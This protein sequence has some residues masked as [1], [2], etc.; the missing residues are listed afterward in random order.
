MTTFTSI[1][2]RSIG[3]LSWIQYWRH[4]SDFKNATG[5]IVILYHGIDNSN[6][7]RLNTKF[8]SARKFEKQIRLIKKH[9]QIVD[10]QTL[11]SEPA[12]NKL[13]VAISFDDGFEN[14]YLVAKP[15]L[16]KYQVPATFF[17]SRPQ[18]H[19]YDILW[20]D[21]VDLATID[22][23]NKLLIDEKPF[24]KKGKEFVDVSGQSLKKMC[25]ASGR[26]F[27]EKIYQAFLPYSRF[28][29]EPKWNTFW[30]LMSEDQIKEISMNPLF[31]VGAHGIMHTS[32]HL[33]S[34]EEA[35]Q[36]LIL[37]KNN[38]ERIIKQPVNWFAYPQGS[39]NDKS[40]ELARTAGYQLQFLADLTNV[41]MIDKVYNRMG[42]NPYLSASAQLFHFFTGKY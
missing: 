33:L 1:K 10:L 25:T 8:I 34:L 30:K 32:I 24:Y 14:N 23:P 9:F 17:I 39:A 16:E 4:F 11:C 6:Q 19:G 18:V 36:E 15:I 5:K 35:Q 13:Q 40:I 20:A 12:G 27:I 42:I 2:Y 38:L 37:S 31:E 22:S 28:R 26:Q 7:I 41:D 21:L 29:I 3:L